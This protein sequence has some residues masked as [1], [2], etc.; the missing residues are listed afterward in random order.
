[1]IQELLDYG[2]SEKE[3]QE[4]FKLCSHKLPIKTKTVGRRELGV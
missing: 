2:L 3:A 1:M 4:T